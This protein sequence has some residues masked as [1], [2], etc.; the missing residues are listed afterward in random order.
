M[1]EERKNKWFRSTEGRLEV[2]VCLFVFNAIECSPSLLI[3]PSLLPSIERSP[4][5]A[6][7][8]AGF[9]AMSMAAAPLRPA[10]LL[11]Q[12]RSAPSAA[13][14]AYSSSAAAAPSLLR[15]RRCRG[16][17]LGVALSR[18]AFC[19]FFLPLFYPWPTESSYGDCRLAWRRAARRLLRERK[20][21][22]EVFFFLLAR[23]PSSRCFFFFPP[24]FFSLSHLRNPSTSASST[25]YP[26]TP[27]R[28]RPSR[29]ST[30]ASPL[31]LLTPAAPPSPPALPPP[32]LSAGTTPPEQ[33][34]PPTTSPTRTTSR[35]TPRS[36]EP[37]GR[38]SSR[39]SSG[40]GRSI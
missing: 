32:L 29:C 35:A 10:R 4:P 13:P 37:A 2:F 18:C 11:L 22:D 24:V 23:E 9:L 31:L 33:R 26:A 6:P 40:T 15:C 39:C 19:Y 36:R 25:F 30:P 20:R 38:P 7:Q 5:L 34:E 3:S 17:S 8:F 16:A 12:Q 27:R 1:T 21:Q 28:P 14:N